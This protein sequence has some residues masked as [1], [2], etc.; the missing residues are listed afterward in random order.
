MYNQIENYMTNVDE[1]MH[2]IE[3]YKHLFK[4]REGSKTFVNIVKNG[5]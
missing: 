5:K 3:K 4:A 1:V 2:L